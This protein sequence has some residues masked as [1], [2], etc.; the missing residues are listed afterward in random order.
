MSDT[1]DDRLLGRTYAH[2]PLSDST[3][4][5]SEFWTQLHSER[6]L[7][8]TQSPIHIVQF[9][10]CRTHIPS[11]FTDCSP[12][13]LQPESLL[14]LNPK[15]SYFRWL[16]SRAAK[17]FRFEYH[18]IYVAGLHHSH[19]PVQLGVIVIPINEFQLTLM[20]TICSPPIV[21]SLQHISWNLDTTRYGRRDSTG[22][23]KPLVRTVGIS[24]PM[25]SI[26]AL[27]SFESLMRQ[28]RIIHRTF[29]C[30]FS[31]DP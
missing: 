12:N 27:R 6:T 26:E 15:H 23:L 13:F 21:H 24:L 10:Y 7:T 11:S 19:G 14:R 4:A 8:F 16:I 18:R 5:V 25:I 17:V 20:P 9:V 3:I 31:L 1:K 30:S 2:A 29:K 22:T 28:S